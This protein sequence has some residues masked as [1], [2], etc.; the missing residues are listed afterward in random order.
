M[1]RVS[2]VHADSG[3]VFRLPTLWP[4]TGMKKSKTKTVLTTQPVVTKNSPWR[5]LSLEKAAS[6]REPKEGKRWKWRERE[7]EREC[8]HEGER[9]KERERLRDRL[10]ADKI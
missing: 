5:C 8:V 4:L 6:G 1:F 10:R 9:K 3:C 7:R 2:R